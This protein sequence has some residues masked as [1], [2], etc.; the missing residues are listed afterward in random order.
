MHS[1]KMFSKKILKSTVPKSTLK[2]ARY[3]K[4]VPYFLYRAK[5]TEPTSASKQD[6]M[7]EWYRASVS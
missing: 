4:K 1:Q 2:K 3:F 7:A 5:S 6:Q